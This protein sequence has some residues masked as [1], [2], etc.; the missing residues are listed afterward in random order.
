[1]AGQIMVGFFWESWRVCGMRWVEG[2][3][4]RRDFSRMGR[5]EEVG[6]YG[7]I[8]SVFLIAFFGDVV[9]RGG[10]GEDNALGRRTMA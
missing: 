8:S 10:G 7:S 2:M 1:M 9:Q 3:D 4:V 6:F 5:G